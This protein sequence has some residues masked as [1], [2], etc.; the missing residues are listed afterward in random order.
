MTMHSVRPLMFG[1]TLLALG[2]C[3]NPAPAAAD[4]TPGDSTPVG[5]D[6]GPSTRVP[7]RIA[8]SNAASAMRRT[9]K[10]RATSANVRLAHDGKSDAHAVGVVNGVD[11]A[12]HKINLTHEP[13]PALGWPSMT[14]DFAVAP[15]VNL[16]ALNPGMRVN[17]T[18][19]KGKGG[20]YEIQSVQPVGAGR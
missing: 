4:R 14:M 3:M 12:R 15:S 17:V 10:D 18:L 13:I 9:D 5:V 6:L 1:I 2:A 20:M 7:S 19:E 8:M 11:P 16:S